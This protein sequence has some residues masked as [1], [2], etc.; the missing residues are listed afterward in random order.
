[1]FPFRQVFL[2]SWA[3]FTFS[4]SNT[5]HATDFTC[6]NS[7]AE[8]AAIPVGLASETPLVKFSNVSDA[9]TDK[10]YQVIRYF[11]GVLYKSMGDQ[12][13]IASVNH[14]TM[15]IRNELSAKNSNES[16]F[17]KL[18]SDTIGYWN[19][20]HPVSSPPLSGERVSPT[21]LGIERS[22]QLI[23]F[24][25]RHDVTSR[26][27]STDD[28]ETQITESMSPS[29]KGGNAKDL[30]D[31]YR[32][33]NLSA[34]TPEITNAYQKQRIALKGTGIG[35]PQELAR[36]YLNNR[37]EF[38]RQHSEKTVQELTAK[39]IDS[40]KQL[41]DN[42]YTAAEQSS[43]VKDHSLMSRLGRIT[44]ADNDACTGM[45]VGK[46]TYVLTAR[47][48]FKEINSH[49]DLWFRPATSQDR[50]QVC[51]IGQ[52]NALS[53]DKLKDVAQ[54]QVIVR[55]APGLKDPAAISVLLK[56]SLRS[57]VE[58]KNGDTTAPTLLTQ[59]SYMPLANT[60]SP[61]RFPSGYV[62]GKSGVCAAKE[63]NKGCFSHFCSM[64]SGGSGSALFV[65]NQKD[66]TLAG[67]HIGDSDKTNNCEESFV[68]NVAT[69]INKALLQ[70]FSNAVKFIGTP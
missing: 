15:D 14:R 11:N 27:I 24:N 16:N 42:C 22:A 25:F 64:E 6:R 53:E 46:G 58:E 30:I 17:I 10:Q 29:P 55:I 45:L 7:T 12:P 5:V 59:I 70:P 21:I 26:T 20:K 36:L 31:R 49:S 28:S 52:A 40:F 60:V 9:S 1:M 13:S 2:I 8:L 69:Y 32:N 39:Y 18:P 51:A 65:A 67:T 57:M 37:N 47:H 19:D 43:F 68:L 63:K 56:S 34:C 66:L 35:L 50:Y 54:D 38:N 4:S 62:Q 33:K 41:I 3:T 44:W 23:A 48:C 61:N